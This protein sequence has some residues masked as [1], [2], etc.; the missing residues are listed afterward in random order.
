MSLLK[1][2]EEPETWLLK[3]KEVEHKLKAKNNKTC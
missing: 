1:F 2:G 3:L